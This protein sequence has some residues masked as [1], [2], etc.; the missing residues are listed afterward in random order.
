MQYV[1]VQY[2]VVESILQALYLMLIG[3]SECE[4]CKNS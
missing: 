1:T 3:I 2:D 4:V